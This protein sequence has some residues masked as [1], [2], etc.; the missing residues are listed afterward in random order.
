MQD[1][2]S[3][4]IVSENSVRIWFSIRYGRQQACNKPK[5]AVVQDTR[6]VS[7]ILS[8]EQAARIIGVLVLLLPRYP[9]AHTLGLTT[10][11]CDQKA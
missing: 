5:A 8:A 3:D 7:D 10:R 2:I 6:H 11:R 1:Q 9:L 4:G